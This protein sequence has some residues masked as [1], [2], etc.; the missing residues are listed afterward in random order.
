MNRS[1]KT[2]ESLRA[3]RLGQ[4]EVQFTLRRSSRRR[5]IGLMVD[6]GMQHSA[7]STG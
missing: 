5:T 6:P 7:I 3:V 1:L 2:A 4:R